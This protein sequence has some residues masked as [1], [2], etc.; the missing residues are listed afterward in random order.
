MQ[1]QLV[2]LEMAVY[3]HP[4]I[5]DGPL[6][7]VV[8][9][10]RVTADQ[11]QNLRHLFGRVWANRAVALTGR[12]ASGKTLTM[13]LILGTLK[14]LLNRQSIAQTH[15]PEV[16]LGD[17]PIQLDVYFYGTD[18]RLYLDKL[19]L[20]P[21]LD[22]P[23][24]WIIQ[25]EQILAKNAAVGSTRKNRF[26]FEQAKTLLD[27]QN[28]EASALALLAPDDSI[29]RSLIVAQ[30]Y[31]VQ[32][33]YDTLMFTNINLVAYG[34]NEVP[35]A[36]LTYLDP[37]IDYLRIERN[38]SGQAF[39]RLKFK[40]SDH[41]ITDSNFAT[42]EYYLSSG[43]AKAV[44]LFQYVQRALKTGGIIFIDELENHFNLA[45]VRAFISFFTDANANPHQAT[46]IFS[47]H[48]ADLLDDLARGDQIYLVRRQ[49]KISV[50]RYST[51][52]DRQD[53]NRAEVIMSDYLGGTA[54]NYQAYL[55]LR[56]KMKQGH[57]N[58]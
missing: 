28:L 46:L 45:I 19:V 32:P 26:D 57:Q 20:A 52:A 9:E 3:H 48:Y 17:Q 38:Q 42:I 15:L 6:F 36:L 55:D 13:K 16:L 10:Q 1:A 29:L 7:S 51:I 5:E 18:Q 4:L 25:S 35:S 47:T 27:R 24:A 43:T 54:P 31:R 30:N 8:N 23:Q 2:F 53:L 44:T 56:E 11:Q 58:E 34:S 40:E 39:Y 21:D 33:I 12:N 49:S 14:L 41:E 37:T 50:A 22:Q